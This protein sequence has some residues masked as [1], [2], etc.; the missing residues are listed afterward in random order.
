M[1]LTR[2]KF[3]RYK[4]AVEDGGIE[5]LFEKRVGESQILKTVLMT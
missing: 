2:D 5:A 1:G 3:Y 4:H